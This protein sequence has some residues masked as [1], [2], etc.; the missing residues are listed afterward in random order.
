[1]Q[2]LRKILL[3]MQEEN[4]RLRADN[5]KLAEVIRKVETGDLNRAPDIANKKYGMSFQKLFDHQKKLFIR[6]HGV[7]GV[8]PTIPTTDYV[9]PT[10]W[11]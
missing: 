3:S 8:I 2:S 10:R 9:I 6:L 5:H 4:K 7:N 1:M 11:T